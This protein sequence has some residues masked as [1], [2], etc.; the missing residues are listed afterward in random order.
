MHGIAL[1]S[2]HQFNVEVTGLQNPSRGGG[3]GKLGSIGTAG[4]EETERFCSGLS[5]IQKHPVTRRRER[6]P[7]G[8]TEDNKEGRRGQKG[9]TWVNR[10]MGGVELDRPMTYGLP[11]ATEVVQ[12]VS[13]G[14]TRFRDQRQIQPW[15]LPGAREPNRPKKALLRHGILRAL[16]ALPATCYDVD[17]FDVLDPT[18]IT[19]R[20]CPTPKR[21][22]HVPFS[23]VAGLAARPAVPNGRATPPIGDARRQRRFFG[24][25]F[26]EKS[27]SRFFAPPDVACDAA[28][29]LC[30]QA[31][32]SSSR[33]PD[34]GA[35]VDLTA[36]M[37]GPPSRC[38]P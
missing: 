37:N 36:T 5:A 8:Q 11:H 16:S 25:R 19:C 2:S 35:G 21:L 1:T 15:V 32:H 20:R 34:F 4:I 7:E 33:P 38:A 28:P 14:H 18:K 22:N 9:K 27:S 30:G 24:S 6:S 3:Y 13:V 12:R 26:V 31:I 17:V 10:P 29:L 23:A